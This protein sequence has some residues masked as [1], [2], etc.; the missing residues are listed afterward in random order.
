MWGKLKGMLKRQTSQPT[1]A[2]SQP[3]RGGIFQ[4]QY[5]PQP[6]Q[7]QQAQA[8]PRS[9]SAWSRRRAYRRLARRKASRF[10]RDVK[11]GAQLTG[12]DVKGFFG[13]LR[14]KLPRFR[15][16]KEEGFPIKTWDEPQRLV[17]EAHARERE[18]E[19]SAGKRREKRFFSLRK[20]NRDPRYEG[21]NW[22]RRVAKKPNPMS[23]INPSAEKSKTIPPRRRGVSKF[24]GHVGYARGLFRAK[25][26]AREREISARKIPHADKGWRDRFTRQRARQRR[27][28]VEKFQ[29][30]YSHSI[31]EDEL[32][33]TPRR[34]IRPQ[35]LPSKKRPSTDLVKAKNR[36]I[37]EAKRLIAMN[38]GQ[39]PRRGT[40]LH[41]NWLKQKNKVIAIEKFL[42]KRR[43]NEMSQQ[44]KFIAQQKLKGPRFKG[45]KNKRQSNR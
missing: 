11:R 31:L 3:V 5:K 36:A 2:P 41:I 34:R 20:D 29:S 45:K 6:A 22:Q 42:G 38:K 12:G 40:K 27:K 30:G 43:T 39:I 15:R 25:Y 13:R 9:R 26:K 10:G 7:S 32:G 1:Q 37:R 16:D 33:L 44:K 18:R 14:S 23:R 24:H 19:I 8:Q 28:E 35:K 21:R 17:D 4:G